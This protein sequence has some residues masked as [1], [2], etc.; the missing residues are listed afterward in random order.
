MPLKRSHWAAGVLLPF[1]SVGAW[2]ADAVTAVDPVVVTAKAP[3]AE[4][5][6]GDGVSL[7]LPD[8]T[9]LSQKDAANFRIEGP[10]DLNALAPNVVVHSGGTRGVNQISGVRGLMNSLSFTD[11]ALVYYVDDVPAS[12]P[13]FN[14]LDPWSLSSLRILEGSQAGRYGQNAPGGIVEATQTQP[15]EAFTSRASAEYGAYGHRLL[16]GEMT[17]GIGKGTGLSMLV[18]GHYESQEG[19]LT[20]PV[21]NTHPDQREEWSGRIALRWRPPTAKEW[22]IDLNVEQTD[23]NDGVQRFTPLSAPHQ[24]APNTLDGHS[25]LQRG[26]QS[27]RAVRDGDG[28]ILTFVSSHRSADLDPSLIN[29]GFNTSSTIAT[30][31]SHEQQYVQEVR[32]ASKDGEKEFLSWFSGLS[33]THV[34]FAASADAA[35]TATTHTLIH[36]DYDS[37]AAFGGVTLRPADDFSLTLSNRFQGDDKGGDRF[38]QT[39][40]GT[41]LLSS[42]TERERRMWLNFA[43]KAEGDYR[44][45]KETTLFASTGLAFR[46]GGYSPFPAQATLAPYASERTWQNEVG[47]RYEAPS[48][49]FRTR[50]AL[51][52]NETYGY[53]LE[54]T[55]YPNSTVENAPEV[56]SRGAEFDVAGEPCEGLTL[57]AGAGYTYATFVHYTDSVSHLSADGL[58]VPYVPRTTYL[59]EGTY[60][61][62]VGWMLHSDLRGL[63]A[64]DYSVLNQSLYRQGAYGIVG[65]RA[66]YESPSGQWAAYLYGENLANAQYSVF[67]DSGLGAQISGDPR[68]YGIAADVRW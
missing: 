1:F 20:N 55:N 50:A 51:F 8:R 10:D 6:A 23:D 43:P 16:F 44:I 28:V 57:H 67:V 15:R 26:V 31:R 39:L 5:E 12:T 29:L 64:T 46:P 41:T 49:H 56:A 3:Q 14:T 68:T 21:L 45:D 30:T 35:T 11:P 58:N 42:S 27:L 59:V 52:W 7:L 19:F 24:I 60:H 25:D 18:S 33:Q 54:R 17:E 61:H 37:Y 13:I 9:T 63:G 4:P 66:G 32:L 22:T 36:A 53:Q 48:Q 65:V 47:A 38:D 40:F 2:A 34:D 62:P